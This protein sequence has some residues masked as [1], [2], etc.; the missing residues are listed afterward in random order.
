MVPLRLT[1]CNKEES[2]NLTDMSMLGQPHLWSL[3][4]AM[5]REQEMQYLE[6]ED[7][8]TL[9]AWV[10]DLRCSQVVC[11]RPAH[12]LGALGDPCQGV[13]PGYVHH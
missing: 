9:H 8:C 5:R 13:Q 12:D 6:E 11:L 3:R 10:E 4:G 2:M 1:I 7:V